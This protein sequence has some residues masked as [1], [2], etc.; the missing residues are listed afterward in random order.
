MGV[1]DEIFEGEWYFEF[2]GERGMPSLRVVFD[3][4][5]MVIALQYY[6]VQ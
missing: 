4:N 2:G 6:T 1:P 5:D 3:E